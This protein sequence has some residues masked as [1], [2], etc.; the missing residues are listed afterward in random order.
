VYRP[1]VRTRETCNGLRDGATAPRRPLRSPASD[2]VSG[3][4]SSGIS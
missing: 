3:P 2:H 4:W 1:G